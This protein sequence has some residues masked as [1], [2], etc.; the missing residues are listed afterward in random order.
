MAMDQTPDSWARRNSHQTLPSISTLSGA[1]RPSPP[2]RDARDARDSGN[3]SMASKHSSVTGG[4]QLPPLEKLETLHPPNLAPHTEHPPNFNGPLN[5]SPH[6]RPG[7]SHSHSPTSGPYGGSNQSTT[8]L[9]NPSPPQYF[10]ESTGLPPPSPTASRR[11]SFDG[12]LNGLHLNSPLNATPS[13]SQVSLASTLNRDRSIHNTSPG[14]DSVANS[15]VGSVAGSSTYSVLS[16]PVSS[17]TSPT[18]GRTAP[19][20]IG[21]SR[22]PYPHPNAP[23]PTKG[24]PY[25]FP[26]PEI[27]GPSSKEP[28]TDTRRTSTSSNGTSIYSHNSSMLHPSHALQAPGLS[29]SNHAGPGQFGNQTDGEYSHHHHFLSERRKP[30][31]ADGSNGATPYSRTPELRISHKLAERKRRKEMKDL[32]DELRDA[33]PAERGGKSSKWEVLTKAI[34]HIHQL[35]VHQDAMQKELDCLRAERESYRASVNDMDRVRHQLTQNHHH[36]SQ[37]PSNRMQGIERGY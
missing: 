26:D 31:L 21:T 3:W 25:A 20:I 24:F 10:G 14:H 12:R 27:A 16:G 32:F 34:E 18:P 11:S 6:S 4:I 13:A 2:L 35:K 19:P 30:L 23:S 28:S 7:Y 8:S 17:M 1:S 33:L 15:V 36:Q 9:H 5:T 22:F 37:Q 29:V